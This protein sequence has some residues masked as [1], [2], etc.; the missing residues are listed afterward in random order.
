MSTT[1]KVFISAGA[2]S[3]VAS[4]ATPKILPKLPASLQ[5][6][7]PLKATHA[8]IA[9]GSAALCYYGLSKLGVTA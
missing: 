9:G 5:T 8:V 1:T 4:W 2:G 3:F 6:G 7:G